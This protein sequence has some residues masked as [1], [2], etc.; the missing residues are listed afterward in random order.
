MS[1]LNYWIWLSSLSGLCAKTAGRLLGKF[2]SPENI[3]NTPDTDL[4]YA[5]SSGFRGKIIPDRRNLE[6]TDKILKT[7]KEKHFRIITIHDKEYP[8]RLKNIYDPPLVLYLNGKLPVIDDEPVVSIVGTRKCTPYGAKAAENIAYKLS[9]RGIIIVTGLAKGID[10]AASYGALRGGTST[11]GVIGSGLDV[12]YPYENRKLFNEISYRGAVISEYPP[13]TKPLTH[14]FPARNRILSG[15]SL[16][17]LVIEAPK[18]SGALITAER[19]LEQGR[20]VF[21]LPGNVD[22]VMCEGSNL[23]IRNGAIPVL[24]AEDII[25]EYEELYPGKI[26]DGVS[27]FENVKTIDNMSNMQYI[28]LNKLLNTL[29]GDEKLVAK[30]IGISNIHVDDII[31]KTKLPAHQV[32]TALTMLEI[33][34]SVVSDGS[35]FFKLSSLNC[36]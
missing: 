9:Q 16:G 36:H 14:N 8:E 19:A 6:D 26:T 23:L 2:D 34:G 10:T 13:G 3:Y 20:D 21:S 25:E 35:K 29:Y 22:A 30:A 5:V 4:L 1:S 18:K 28:D 11:L 7:C 31:T 17:V 12:I 27:E 15:L 24:S 33:N 32:L